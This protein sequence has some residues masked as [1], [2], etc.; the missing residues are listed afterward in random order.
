MQPTYMPWA[1]YFNLISQANA[2]VFLDDVQF[3]R[4]TWQHRNRVLVHGEPHW[5]T[6]PCIRHTLTQSIHTVDIDDRRNWRDKHIK[7]LQQTYGKHPH[8]PD[9]LG[10]S[11]ILED[12]RLTRLVDLNTQLIQWFCQGLE[13]SVPMRLA[14]DMAVSGQRSGRLVKI[15]RDLQ[16][17][18]YL[19]PLGA[20]DYLA[21][22]GD[23]EGSGIQLAFQ[24]YEPPPYT[25]H[26]HSGPFVSHLSMLDVL[27]NLG[28]EKAT[29]YVKTGSAQHEPFSGASIL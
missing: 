16:C 29:Y 9:M 1:G 15:C 23:F 6:V 19:S 18:R 11:A 4:S 26:A 7:L 3:Q 24:S 10:I 21:T 25:Q 8:G 12:T 27:A 22:D 5:L 17:S 14:S 28:W 2:F 13:L 20:A